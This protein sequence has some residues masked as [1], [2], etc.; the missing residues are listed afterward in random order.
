[1]RASALLGEDQIGVRGTVAVARSVT[2][3]HDD[4]ARRLMQPDTLTLARSAHEAAS[5]G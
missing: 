1:M 2:D 4:A 5:G 3:E